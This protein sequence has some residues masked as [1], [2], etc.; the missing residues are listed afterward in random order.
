MESDDIGSLKVSQGICLLLVLD[1]GHLHVE[2]GRADGGNEG[3]VGGRDANAV[4][5]KAERMG[6]W[7]S[8]KFCPG[9]Y[10]CLGSGGL[11]HCSAT[12]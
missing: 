2:L 5:W 4:T 10:A 11:D 12:S 9:H 6:E 7:L 3:C 8:H 1:V